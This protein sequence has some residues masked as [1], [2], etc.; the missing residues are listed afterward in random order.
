MKRLTLGATREGERCR[1]EKK[2]KRDGG[3]AG[4]RRMGKR[5]GRGIR[6]GGDEYDGRGLR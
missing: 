1:G 4:C 5:H 2:A 3:G 6:R